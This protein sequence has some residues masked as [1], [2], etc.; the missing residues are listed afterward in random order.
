LKRQAIA[1]LSKGEDG[2]KLAKADLVIAYQQMQESADLTRTEM[3]ELF[4]AWVAEFQ[5]AKREAGNLMNMGAPSSPT[6]SNAV[7]PELSQA[8]NIM[9]L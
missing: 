4:E 8:I 2:F 3:K 6:G 5:E 9:A 1:A 7:S